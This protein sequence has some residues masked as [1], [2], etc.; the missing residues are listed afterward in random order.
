MQTAK[1]YV[2][3]HGIEMTWDADCG[4]N[5]GEFTSSDGTLNQIW[6]EDAESI[7]AKL[8]AMKSSGIAGVAA[9]RLGYETPDIW[10]EIASFVNG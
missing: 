10:D 5:Y 1:E 7:G 2:A 4:Q 6:M 9:W 3:N 8:T